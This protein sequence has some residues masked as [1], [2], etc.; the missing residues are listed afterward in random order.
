MSGNREIMRI[1]R[2]IVAGWK[3]ELTK[4]EP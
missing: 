2:A 1:A 4:V 3:E